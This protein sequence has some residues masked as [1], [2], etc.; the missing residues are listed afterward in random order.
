L[1]TPAE[2][3]HERRPIFTPLSFH[4]F[5]TPSALEARDILGKFTRNRPVTVSS[6]PSLVQHLLHQCNVYPEETGYREHQ[7]TLECHPLW[8]RLQSNIPFY[9][10]TDGDTAI[11]ESNRPSRLT[12]H[13]PPRQILLSTATLIVL[14]SHLLVQ[15]NSEISKHCDEGFLRV[16]VIEANTP[17]PSA[18]ALARDFD[19][20]IVSQTRRLIVFLAASVT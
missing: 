20:V 19:I 1:P 15:W 16:V 13:L 18:V 8:P 17:M 11:D 4:H 12:N 7:S 9:L 3:W 14:P 2:A 6:F 5:R 10:Q